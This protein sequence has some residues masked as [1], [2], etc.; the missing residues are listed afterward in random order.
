[1]YNQPSSHSKTQETESLRTLKE[2]L[3]MLGE[4]III[5]DLN[6]H[7]SS[8]G[9][10]SYPMQHKL[11]DNLLDIIQDADLNL[12]L[13]QGTITR[14]CQRG[15]NHEQTIID[16]VFTTAVL[17]QQVVRCGVEMKVDQS[18]DHLP[19]CTEFEW[20]RMCKTKESK[21]QRAWKSINI[22]K[23]SESLNHR[24]EHLEDR[25]LTTRAEI[26]QL[27]YKLIKDIKSAVEDST[28]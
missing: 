19:I 10:P 28:L 11:A 2:A 5:G 26:N 20:E 6:L 27:M 25:L 22:E 12:T 15:N 18:L 3:K 13:P 16:L 24:T 8:W 1:V 17:E 23:F 14:D 7:H 4:H 21:S 9:G